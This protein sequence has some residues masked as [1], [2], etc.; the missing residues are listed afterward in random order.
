MVGSID[1]RYGNVLLDANALEP[2]DSRR[3]PAIE[4]FRHHV[5]RLDLSLVVPSGVRAEISHPRTPTWVRDAMPE[6][7]VIPTATT[8]DE[9]RLR[10]DLRQVIRGQAAEGRHDRDADH[11]FDAQK[12]GGR[13][14]ITHDTRLLAMQKRIAALVPDFRILTLVEFNQVCTEF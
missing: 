12:Y 2:V 8:D 9:R 1:P 11:I 13:Y 10:D 4:E 3:T 6:V 5:E 7:F 14:F